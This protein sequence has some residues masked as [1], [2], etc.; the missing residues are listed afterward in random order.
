M[1]ILL[2]FVIIA[3]MP[4]IIKL[5]KI[6]LLFA[7]GK[8]NNGTSVTNTTQRRRFGIF[9]ETNIYISAFILLIFGDAEK[10]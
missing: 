2:W 3:I 8:T 5:L 6:R 7:P 10:T 9:C 1:G 4:V